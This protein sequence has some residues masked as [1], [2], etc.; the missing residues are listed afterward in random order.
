MKTLIQII[1]ATLLTLTAVAGD[2]VTIADAKGS[3]NLPAADYA[4]IIEKNT[5]N[6]YDAH[7]PDKPAVIGKLQ[8]KDKPLS[9]N[10]MRSFTLALLVQAT[11][12]PDDSIWLIIDD[13][14]TP[15]RYTAI[16]KRASSKDVTAV[17]P[18]KKGN[19]Q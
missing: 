10:A 14:Y 7:K 17:I 2:V 16:I 6:I 9:K 1:I 15:A 3:Q 5:I 11:V 19:E 12:P 8:D 13:Q 4:V 18:N